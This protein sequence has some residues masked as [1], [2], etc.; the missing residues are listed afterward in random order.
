MAAPSLL[1]ITLRQLIHL[2]ALAGI[3]KTAKEL[4]QVLQS[5]PFRILPAT[6]IF[7]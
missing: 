5:T 3:Y 1:S 7:L 2:P 6:L 4:T